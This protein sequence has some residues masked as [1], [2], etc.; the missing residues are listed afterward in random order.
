MGSAARIRFQTSFCT[1]RM[2]A[3]RHFFLVEFVVHMSLSLPLGVADSL[4]VTV[5]GSSNPAYSYMTRYHN[6]ADE[7]SWAS[8]QLSTLL[9]AEDVAA[10]HLVDVNGD[11]LLDYVACANIHT[12]TSPRWQTLVVDPRRGSVS[13]IDQPYL[14]YFAPFAFGGALADLAGCSTA[15]APAAFRY[16]ANSGN[17][18]YALD[19]SRTLLGA[20]CNGS[21]TA[22]A[23]DLTGDGQPE[24]I[25]LPQAN[26]VALSIVA[27]DRLGNGSFLNR[28]AAYFPSPGA[29]LAEGGSGSASNT[30]KFVDLNADG[31]LDLVQC[32]QDPSFIARCYVYRHNS[33]ANTMT[34]VANSI[35]PIS[36][37]ALDAADLDGDGKVDLLVTG[38]VQNGTS[39]LRAYKGDGSFGFTPAPSI[40]FPFAPFFDGT[41]AIL[42]NSVGLG[43]HV[44][45]SVDQAN[46]ALFV[47]DNTGVFSAATLP[48]SPTL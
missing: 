2:H 40:T 39:V 27:A 3:L 30:V 37:G 12:C 34:L 46:V 36:L 6:I 1:L 11:G 35:L 15:P 33:P 47:N 5:T 20:S 41:L 7:S 43:T 32:G 45:T 8:A 14:F 17:G 44:F 9:Q 21:Y 25:A 24:L 18:S 38:A 28:G 29:N 22:Y 23:V 31:F 10:L 48:Q 19:P 4:A 42:K 16:Y 13:V 26:L